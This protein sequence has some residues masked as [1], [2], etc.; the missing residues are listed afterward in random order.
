MLCFSFLCYNLISD[1]VY[2]SL[3][4]FVLMSLPYHIGVLTRMIDRVI[5]LLTCSCLEVDE[6]EHVQSVNMEASFTC[7]LQL[8]MWENHPLSLH[9]AISHVQS[10]NIF[11]VY[12]SVTSWEIWTTLMFFLPFFF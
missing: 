7:A 5:T 12:S 9:I 1:V 11:A 2:S 6:G 10:V 8:H 4:S 3:T